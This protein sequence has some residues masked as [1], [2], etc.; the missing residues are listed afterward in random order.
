MVGR[1]FRND[2]LRDQQGAALVVS[3]FHFHLRNSIFSST[4][5]LTLKEKL[6]KKAVKTV[7]ADGN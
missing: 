2:S 3:E 5:C 6:G 7:L 1:C 4:Q